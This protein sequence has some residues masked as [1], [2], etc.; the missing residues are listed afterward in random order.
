MNQPKVQTSPKWQKA[1]QSAQ[2]EIVN[3]L[4]LDSMV[5]VVTVVQQFMTECSDAVS[6][7]AKIQAISKTIVSGINAIEANISYNFALCE[8][9]NI[10][11]WL[12]KRINT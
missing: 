10:G 7:E 11:E 4:L 9:R 2:A 1:G 3:S 12:A 6:K 8:A 5:R